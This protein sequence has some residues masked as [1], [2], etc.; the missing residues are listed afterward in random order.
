MQQRD[1]G[2]EIMV[3]IVVIAVLAF[4]IAFSVI[5]SLTTGEP[6]PTAIAERYTLTA[7]TQV[8]TTQATATNTRRAASPSPTDTPTTEPTAE[9]TNTSRPPTR[10]TAPT[11]QPSNTRRP[12]R[13]P[14]PTEA[15][16]E[17]ASSTPAATTR[18]AVTHTPTATP[19]LT[20][21]AAIFTVE[22]TRT[23]TGTINP[24]ATSRVSAPGDIGIIPTPTGGFVAVVPTQPPPTGACI[25][26]PS[27][28][29][30]Y[31]VQTGNTLFSIAL[32][33][34]S[35]VPE[36]LRVNCLSDADRIFAGQVLYVPRAP[37]GLVGMGVPSVSQNDCRNPAQA[38][39]SA[40]S[41]GSRVSSTFAVSGTA[42]LGNFWYYRIEIRP[43]TSQTYNFWSQ[44]EASIQ[45][46][47]LAQIDSTLFADGL[48]WVR[49]SVID[50]TG[51]IP[52]D[53]ICTVPVYIEN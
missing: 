10:T 19:T 29:T 52:F 43:D 9:A 38:Q 21:I 50:L 42:A 46:G 53:A 39:I 33:V 1:V 48:H 28:W 34:R 14:E 11:E 31:T 37:E 45:N 47:E 4:A 49:L 8:V 35:S 20:P 18:A 6:A 27:G 51:G 7:T 3:A 16:T 40:P 25:S 5:L 23:R 32:A 41:A 13:T 36:L 12:S 22:P 24:S 17:R 44:R 15:A 26:V 2:N 30:T